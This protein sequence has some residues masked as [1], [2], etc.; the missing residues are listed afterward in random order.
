MADIRLVIP[1]RE[2]LPGYIAALEAGWSPDNLRPQVAQ[3]QLARIAEDAEGFL[4]SLVDREARGGPITLPDGSQ[5]QRLPGYTL[6]IVDGE[7]CGS[8][9]FRW[10]PGTTALPP[11]CP[12]HIGYAIVPWKRNRGYARQALALML[13][14]A[15]REGLDEVAITTDPGNVA[16]QRVIEANGGREPERFE[17]GPQFG[18]HSEGLRYRVRTPELVEES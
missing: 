10:M 15:R 13:R 16:S 11:T 5:V 3:E 1:S 9:N 4:A 6:W 14:E 18:D 12:G 8:I 2:H 17:R 7:F